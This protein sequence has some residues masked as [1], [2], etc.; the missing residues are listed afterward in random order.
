MFV[1][2]TS[3]L[4]RYTDL[5]NMHQL[6]SALRR[7]ITPPFNLVQQYDILPLCQSRGEEIKSLQ[8]DSSRFWILGYLHSQWQADPTRVYLAI[9]LHAH[10]GDGYGQCSV[11]LSQFGIDTECQIRRAVLRGETLQVR[12]EFV[13]P[14]FDRLIIKE[15]EKN[16]HMY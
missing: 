12:V 6:K 13:N 8:N 3:P 7:E 10:S 1:S 2:I 15:V 4:R 14:F 11:H 9:V 16:L 5:L